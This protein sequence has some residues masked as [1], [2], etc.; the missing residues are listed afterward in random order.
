MVKEH[1][2]S[3]GKSSYCLNDDYYY[4]KIA[5]RG[6][7]TDDKG[8]VV[9]VEKGSGTRKYGASACMGRAKKCRGHRSPRVK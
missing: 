8:V 5:E 4:H 9:L 7:I 6:T 2:N 3:I 1:R